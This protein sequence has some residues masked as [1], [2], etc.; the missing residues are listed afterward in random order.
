M[1][2]LAVS[3]S[4]EKV[5]TGFSSVTC[6]GFGLSFANSS[7]FSGRG[8]AMSEGVTTGMTMPLARGAAAR[9]AGAAA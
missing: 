5:E 8:M 4:A 3:T 9:G 6:T 1:A 2:Q 7:V